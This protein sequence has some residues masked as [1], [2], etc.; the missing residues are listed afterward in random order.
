M[1]EMR[2]IRTRVDRTAIEQAPGRLTLAD[3]FCEQLGG[4]ERTSAVS[5]GSAE[6]APSAWMAP[7]FARS[8]SPCRPTGQATMVEELVALVLRKAARTRG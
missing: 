5:P 1:I 2:P 4:T 3:L 8:S 6:R 7:R